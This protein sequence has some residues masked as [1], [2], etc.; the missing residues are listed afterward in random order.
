MS[1]ELKRFERLL[2]GQTLRQV[3]TEWRDEVLKAARSAK[4]GVATAR[5]QDASDAGTL[6]ILGRLSF[7]FWPHPVAWGGLAAVWAFLFMVNFSLRD[8]EP[9]MAEKAVPQSA[10]VMAQLQ[11]QH[12]LLAELLGPNDLPDADR[13]KVFVPKPRSE[14]LEILSA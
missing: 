4:S 7:W 11:Q 14:C 13:P 8:R 9:V 5:L 6:T 3:P 12:R 1:D 10:V 2:E